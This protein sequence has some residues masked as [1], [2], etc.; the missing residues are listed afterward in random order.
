MKEILEKLIKEKVVI[1]TRSS[2]V[3]I[4]VL[5]R[6]VD[7]CIELL[8]VDVHDRRDTATSKEIYILDSRRT[9]V[10]SNRDRVFVNMDYIISF[11]KLDDVKHF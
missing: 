10:K 7:N 1:D 5:E 3:Y 6:V 2:W 4:G 8:E 9:G 11:S